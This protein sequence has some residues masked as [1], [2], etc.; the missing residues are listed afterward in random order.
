M[1]SPNPGLL[2]PSMP[3]LGFGRLRAAQLYFTAF[4]LFLLYAALYNLCSHNVEVTG[5]VTTASGIL[6]QYEHQESETVQLL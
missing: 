2:P 4:I 1:A 5:T 6:W 3:Q